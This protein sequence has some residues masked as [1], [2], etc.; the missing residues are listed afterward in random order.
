MSQLEY[1][2]LSTFSTECKFRRER[3]VGE[4]KNKRDMWKGICEIPGISTKM[5]LALGG[6]VTSIEKRM[7]KVM[8][9]FPSPF[10]HTYNW[11]IMIHFI[12]RTTVCMMLTD[13]HQRAPLQANYKLSWYALLM[14]KQFLVRT[15]R[16]EKKIQSHTTIEFNH[17][18]IRLNFDWK[19]DYLRRT[20]RE[21]KNCLSFAVTHFH[22][23]LTL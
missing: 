9:L 5:D 20:K 4:S 8:G 19:F 2:L 21:R 3:K 11:I 6:L 7:G 14:I 18:F 15:F 12:H 16:W 10:V 17:S 23:S 1:V 13:C 22:R